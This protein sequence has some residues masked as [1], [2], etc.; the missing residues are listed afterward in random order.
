MED[1]VLG[2]FGRRSGICN[3]LF[4]LPDKSRTAPTGQTHPQNSLPKQ[5]VV[6]SIAK[7]SRNNTGGCPARNPAIPVKGSSQLSQKKNGWE[8]VG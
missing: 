7:D 3:N 5:A 8:S 2:K 1:K 6:T 4:K